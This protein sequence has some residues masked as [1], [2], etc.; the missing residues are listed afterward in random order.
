L[1]GHAEETS[2]MKY[3]VYRP[4]L[5]GRE[6]EYVIE[7]LDSSWISSKGRFVTEFEERFAARVGVPR[8][9]SVCNGTVALHAALV[10]LGIGPGDEVIVPTLTYIASVNAISYT[11][12]IPRFVDSEKTFWQLDPHAVRSLVTPRTKA[13]LAVHLYG[14]ACD[15]DALQRIAAEHG[16]FV[17]EDCAEALGSLIGHQSVGSFGDVATFSF[18][19][20]KTLTT[21]EGGMVVA[22]TLAV[23][24]R[25]AKLKGQGLAEGREYWHDV[26]GF[27][28]RMTNIC[29]A[30][31][32]AQLDGLD[33][34][35]HRK[36]D[37]ARWYARYLDGAPVI[38]QPTREGTFNSYWMVSLLTHHQRDREPLRH[39]LREQGIETRPLFPPAHS[40]P[41]YC[42]DGSRFPVAEDLASRGLNVPSYP[43][44]EEA[45]V[46]SICQSIRAYFATARVSA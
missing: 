39:F 3:P 16:L 12:A 6:K 1:T 13:I 25:V 19:G 37:L 27:N 22:K 2:S 4:M 20:N 5:I 31:G 8:A 35:L 32:C 38:L 23:A 11:G 34:I 21:G 24:D 40:M 44:L 9:V 26:V 7:C 10:A 29:A 45:D 42:H 15:M 43:G 14:Q 18:Y 17:V 28:Y 41:M 33:E 36:Q 46:R 30:I